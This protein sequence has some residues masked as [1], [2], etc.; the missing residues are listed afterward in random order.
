[1]ASK[2]GQ[3]NSEAISLLSCRKASVEQSEKY[4]TGNSGIME[5]LKIQY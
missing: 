3:A 2:C 4:L 5:L 1:M